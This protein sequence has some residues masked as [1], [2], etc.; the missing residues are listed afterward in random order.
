M[1]KC[2]SVCGELRP[3]VL[4]HSTLHTYA[5]LAESASPSYTTSTRACKRDRGRTNCQRHSRAFTM[6]AVARTTSRLR[7][8]RIHSTIAACLSC[9]NTHFKRSSRHDLARVPQDGCAVYVSNRYSIRGLSKPAV[10]S[11]DKCGWRAGWMAM[12]MSKNGGDGHW[13]WR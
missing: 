4:H 9:D 7:T 8:T 10:R 1:S 2:P 5:V 11:C 3:S 13:K 12:I 6:H